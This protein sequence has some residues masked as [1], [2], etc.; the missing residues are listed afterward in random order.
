MLS[1]F[2]RDAFKAAISCV[3]KKHDEVMLKLSSA[4]RDLRVSPE[5]CAPTFTKGPI[6]PALLMK[7][8]SSKVF[9]VAASF[10]FACLKSADAESSKVS[11]LPRSAVIMSTSVDRPAPAVG[12]HQTKMRHIIF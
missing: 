11:K 10:F 12:T 3:V 1:A 5:F 4:E 2:K 8:I 9:L 7:M 6:D